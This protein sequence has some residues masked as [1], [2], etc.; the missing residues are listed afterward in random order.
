MKISHQEEIDAA[1]EALKLHAESCE[2]QAGLVELDKRARE[3]AA[4]YVKAE[5]A[6]SAYHAHDPNNELEDERLLLECAKR[7]KLYKIGVAVFFRWVAE[8]GL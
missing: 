7:G 6:K 2:A 8:R 5:A 3:V 4:L 1:V